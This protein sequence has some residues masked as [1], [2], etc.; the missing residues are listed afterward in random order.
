M[1]VVVARFALMFLPTGVMN[2]TTATRSRKISMSENAIDS[3]N[4]TKPAP[5]VAR[6]K[7]ARKDGKKATPAKKSARV[8][9]RFIMAMTSAVLL[10]RSGSAW[11]LPS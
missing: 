9:A 4:I 7:G 8:L 1:G 11:Q 2:V 5:N 3:E 10:A 6:S